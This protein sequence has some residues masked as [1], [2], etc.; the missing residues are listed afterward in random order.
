MN[1]TLGII[2][3]T[4]L[5]SY[6]AFNRHDLFDKLKFNPPRILKEKEYY[7]L[8]SYALLHGGWTHLL[9]N[10]FVLYS[11]GSA[12]EGYFYFIFGSKASVNY[13]LLYIGA[14]IF[15]NLY[16]LIKHKDDYF[17]NAVGAS[18]GVSAI[19]FASVL[20]DPWGKIYFFGVLP[21]PGIVFGVI[22]LYYCYKMN[23]QNSD[24]V[25]HDAHFLGAVFGFI[26]PILMQPR[27]FHIFTE[28]LLNLH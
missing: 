11:F 19:L 28:R 10:M 20:F 8:L 16:A 2:I 14:L 7:R 24:N 12:V 26:F 15:C 25:A 1:V 17:Y 18:G 3:I 21:I 23:K 9:I 13:L 27:I 5:V 4:G 22:Y 6:M